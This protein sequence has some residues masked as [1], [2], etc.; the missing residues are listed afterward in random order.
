MESYFILGTGT[1]VGKTWAS[2]WLCRRSLEQGRR[3]AYL[4][5]VQTG[6]DGLVPSDAEWVRQ[7]CGSNLLPGSLDLANPYRYT[8][9]AS[10]HLAARIDGAEAP[11]M[12]E[13]ATAM[14]AIVAADV[15]ELL[16]VESAGGVASP[17]RLGLSMGD[18][19]AA[20]KIPV[21]L[22]TNPGLGT[23]SATATALEYLK[24]RGVVPD[25]LIV[26]GCSPEPDLVE[27]DNLVRLREMAGAGFFFAL[28][29]A[30]HP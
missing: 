3:T 25:G 1:G 20:L 10:P 13:I 19:A 30:A 17:M 12:A 7:Q 4:K 14:A 26:S 5:P 21:I 27:A 15:P 29:R 22:V 2:A 8:L 28:P 24:N 23:L 16:V 18:V 6:C 9:A 11:G